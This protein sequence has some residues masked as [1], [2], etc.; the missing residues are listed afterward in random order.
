MVNHETEANVQKSESILADSLNWLDIKRQ[1]KELM[2]LMQRCDEQEER[3]FIYKISS[4]E[5]ILI[6]IL[7]MLIIFI[8]KTNRKSWNTFGHLDSK[9]EPAE[10]GIGKLKLVRLTVRNA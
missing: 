6:F 2:H 5:A 9:L 3:F 7:I 4:G 1:S 10:N 8:A